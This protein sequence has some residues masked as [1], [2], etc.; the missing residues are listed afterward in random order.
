MKKIVII[1]CS[2]V[3][4]MVWSNIGIAGPKKA[5]DRDCTAAKAGK[6][7]AMKATV[8]V[9]GPCGPADAAK[10]TAKDAVG[11]EDKKDKKKRKK[12]DNKKFKK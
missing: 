8:G 2:F 9:G 7:M 3:V 12:K 6:N 5:L 1:A 10:D 11:L 4:L